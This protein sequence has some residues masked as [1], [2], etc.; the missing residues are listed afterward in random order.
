M[1]WPNVGGYPAAMDRLDIEKLVGKMVDQVQLNGD[2]VKNE[3]EDA[4]FLRRVL[5]RSFRL[6]G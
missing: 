4:D 5:T 2:G 6:P 1:R 3:V